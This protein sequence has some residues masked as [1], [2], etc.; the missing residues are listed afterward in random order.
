MSDDSNKIQDKIDFLAQI[1]PKER[2]EVILSYVRK[3]KRGD[4]K[5]TPEYIEGSLE[6]IAEHC[7]VSSAAQIAFLCEF[8]ESRLKFYE[9]AG[10]YGKAANSAEKLELW[11]RAA[12]NYQLANEPQNAVECLRKG[13]LWERLI[14]LAIN[15]EAKYVDL[16]NMIEHEAND[17]PRADILRR[18]G[19]DVYL[20]ENEPDYRS[21]AILAHQLG[22]H[23]KVL[24][25]WEKGDRWIQAAADEKA[26]GMEDR[27][28]GYAV[29]A[30]VNSFLEKRKVLPS[31]IIANE[32]EI[33][34]EF[35]ETVITE[36]KEEATHYLR[37]GDSF[38][39]FLETNQFYDLAIEFSL[40]DNNNYQEAARFAELAGDDEQ[41]DKFNKLYE[42]SR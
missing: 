25:I 7:G 26:Y 29:K 1:S 22:R 34:R 10:D 9:I 32:F 33:Q 40:M 13:E 11:G 14:P 24:R 5:I 37:G 41:R 27:A 2:A 39:N 6:E 15:E 38:C 16:A 42:L 4:E 36:H 3:R 18:R 19:I 35:A 31:I 12:T 8:E 20:N 21:A 23:E 17:K 28:K 30:A